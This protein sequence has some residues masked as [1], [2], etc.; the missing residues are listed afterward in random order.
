MKKVNLVGALERGIDA[1][2]PEH[3]WDE[4]KIHVSDLS[5][6][7]PPSDRK[8][9]REL[10][11]RYNN[12]DR[13]E[14]SPGKKLMFLQGDRLHE[15]AAE[16]IDIGLNYWELVDTERAVN[17]Q[18]ITGRYDAKLYNETTNEYM[19]IDFKTQRG[20][21]FSY[22]HEP[23]ASHK[24][25]VQSYMEATGIK[26]GAIIYIDREGSNFAKQ[27]YIKPDYAEVQ[28]GID[29]AKTIIKKN[30]PPSRM[31]P[32]FTVNQNKGDN[33]IQVKLPWQCK[34]CNF[35]KVT[36]QSAVPSKFD[37]KIGKVCGHINQKGF[38][39]L[40]EVEGIEEYVEPVLKQKEVI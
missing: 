21:A 38:T 22:L 9:H 28:K 25:Q 2:K 15:M 6:V 29:L 32:N 26:N 36:C 10:W 12:Y 1:M 19:I 16:L 24:L 8:C 13:Q 40:D 23:K 3:E 37:D 14:N 18:K 33:S 34:Y 35:R 27:F 31:K 7:L 30:D 11:Y 17:L 4:S 39:P 20:G 5:V